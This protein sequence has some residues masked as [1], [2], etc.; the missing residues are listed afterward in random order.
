VEDRTA[1]EPFFWDTDGMDISRL[2]SDDVAVEE[3]NDGA[4]VWLAVGVAVDEDFSV[5]DGIMVA[6]DSDSK[7]EE[8]SVVATADPV[9]TVKIGPN[10]WLPAESSI[11]MKNWSPGVANIP[12][13]QK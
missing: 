8:K 11:F 12:G 13:I 6:A 7:E 9:P 4:V 2:D 3:E 10:A 5:V 1:E